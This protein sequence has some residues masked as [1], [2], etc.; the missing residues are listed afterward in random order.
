M[1]VA[2]EAEVAAEVTG[3]VDPTDVTTMTTAVLRVVAEDAVA[4]EME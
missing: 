4:H 1:I 2:D 3:M